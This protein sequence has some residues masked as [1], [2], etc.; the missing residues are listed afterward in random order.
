MI[1]HDFDYV[2]DDEIRTARLRGGELHI[3]RI[4]YAAL[5]LPPLCELDRAVR[6]KVEKLR[7]AGF[8]VLTV[9]EAVETLPPTLRIEP[10]AWDLLVMKRDLGHGEA[11]YMVMN[12]AE[13]SRRVELTAPERQ[14]VSA[15]D[16]VRGEFRSNNFII[17]TIV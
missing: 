2:S 15:V 10:A 17:S 1:Q 12:T 16:A 3:G 5:V 11:L 6:D 14:P 8:P 4:S 7:R 9:G 13:T